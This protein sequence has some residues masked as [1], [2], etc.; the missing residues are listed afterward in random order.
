MNVLKET[1]S[2]H[3]QFLHMCRK[4]PPT[5]FLFFQSSQVSFRHLHYG[6]GVASTYM[7]Y[8]CGD[9]QQKKGGGGNPWGA[10]P[11]SNT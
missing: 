4:R 5:H 6:E 1:L 7:T 11:F 9:K 10:Q 3:S 2:L 8:L